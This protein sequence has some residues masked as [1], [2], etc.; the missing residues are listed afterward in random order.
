MQQG[1]KIFAS[2]IERLGLHPECSSGPCKLRTASHI[3]IAQYSTQLAATLSC[4]GRHYCK[5]LHANSNVLSAR[6]AESGS[7]AV[8][9]EQARVEAELQRGKAGNAMKE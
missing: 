2:A 8:L 4:M 1:P 9:E 6:C 7:Q 5:Q 3:Q